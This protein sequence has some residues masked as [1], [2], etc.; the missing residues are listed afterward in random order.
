MSFPTSSDTGNAYKA[1]LV[2]AD[3]DLEVLGEINY[4]GFVWTVGSLK[5]CVDETIFRG[6]DNTIKPGWNFSCQSQTEVRYVVRKL[7]AA[8]FQCLFRGDDTSV[9][10]YQSL[11][12][13]SWWPRLRIPQVFFSDE[14]KPWSDGAAGSRFLYP[15]PMVQQGAVYYYYHIWTTNTKLQRFFY[16]RS[17]MYFDWRSRLSNFNPSDSESIIDCGIVRSASCSTQKRQED[18]S[19]RQL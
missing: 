9:T 18:I 10:S 8:N 2:F 13:Q 3:T 19:A 5:T 11:G 14:L 15:K 12:V 17:E 6:K 7:K 1:S 16:L 4:N